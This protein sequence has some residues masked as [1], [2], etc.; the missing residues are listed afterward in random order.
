MT[1]RQW[2]SLE[3]RACAM[4][5]ACQADEEVYGIFEERSPRDLWSRLHMLYIGKNICNKLMLNK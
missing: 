2:V 5:R 1:N 4:I 3:K